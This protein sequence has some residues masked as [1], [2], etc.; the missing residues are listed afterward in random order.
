MSHEDDMARF[1]AR[2]Q[3]QAVADAKADAGIA[4]G[5]KITR[6]MVING[7]LPPAPHPLTSDVEPVE[8]ETPKRKSKTH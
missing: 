7:P 1:A 3:A 5:A 2:R 4:L 6:E 8:D